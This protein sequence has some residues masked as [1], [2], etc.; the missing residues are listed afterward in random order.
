[1]KAF[2]PLVTADRGR[3]ARADER[4]STFIAASV[5]LIHAP[6]D[7]AF[8]ISVTGHILA[9]NITLRRYPAPRPNPFRP[10]IARTYP[11]TAR[12]SLARAGAIS[13]ANDRPQGQQPALGWQK[14]SA[15]FL[16]I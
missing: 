13:A 16:S 2:R 4:P 9:Q 8:P 1:M 7:R 11:H 15:P 3:F 6:L 12:A 10:C 5:A 14:P